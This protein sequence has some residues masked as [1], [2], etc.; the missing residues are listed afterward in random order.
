MSFKRAIQR[1]NDY[2]GFLNS[3]LVNGNEQEITKVP[4]FNA[5]QQF[6]VEASE[7]EIEIKIF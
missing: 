5:R 2:R 6:R 3:A 7:R 4:L 1:L